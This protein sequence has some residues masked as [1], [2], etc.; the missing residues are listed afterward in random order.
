MAKLLCVLV[1]VAGYAGEGMYRRVCNECHLFRE[2]QQ[3]QKQREEAQQAVEM[4]SA[5]AVSIKKKKWDLTVP[6]MAQ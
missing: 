5:T 3:Q 6:R 1:W 4:K 2:P